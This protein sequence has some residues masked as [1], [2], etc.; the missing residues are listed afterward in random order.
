M[1]RELIMFMKM[2]MVVSWSCLALDLV[3][4]PHAGV[5]MKAEGFSISKAE[6]ASLV[7][8][9]SSMGSASERAV[10]LYNQVCAQWKERLGSSEPLQPVVASQKQEKIIDVGLSLQSRAADYLFRSRHQ[11]AVL[12]VWFGLA[13]LPRGVVDETVEELKGELLKSLPKMMIC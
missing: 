6:Y 3:Q 1:K 13:S 8:H 7:A 11:M 10:S 4:N 12:R 5:V 2:L 9:A